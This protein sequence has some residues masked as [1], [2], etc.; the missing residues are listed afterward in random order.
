MFDA[1]K[2]KDDVVLWIR[3]WFEKNGSNCNAVIGISGGKDSSVAAALC[4]EALGKDRVIGIL[5]PNGEQKD[6]SMAKMLVEHLGI[7][8]Y[9][10]NIQASVQGIL[11]ELTKQGIMATDQTNTNL[12]ARIR[13]STLYAV[14]QSMNGRVANTC[15][16][17]EDWVGYSTRYGDAAGDFSPLSHL[18]V[19]EVKAIGYELSLPL[20]LIEKIPIDG[21]TDKTDEDN[22]GFTYAVLDRYIRTGEI[23]DESVK[24][25]IDIMHKRNQFKLE[26]MPCFVLK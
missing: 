14:S 2:V 5:M 4:V 24:A 22:L 23:E 21:L 16:L 1:K 12:P 9:E 3:E 8:S 20:E 25:K 19:S 17:S 18:T 15:N 10:I 7:T 26:L 13:M 11:S 6:I